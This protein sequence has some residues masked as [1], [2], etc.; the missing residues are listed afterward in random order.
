M[1]TDTEPTAPT[2]GAPE[3]LRI[4]DLVDIALTAR[5]DADAATARAAALKAAAV[6]EAERIRLTTGLVDRFPSQQ[7]LG[8]LRLD[9]ADAPAVAR[10]TKGEEFADFLAQHQSDAVTT[11]ITVPA[12]QLEAALQALEFASV[13]GVTAR[14]DPGPGAADFLERRCVIQADKDTGEWTVL[15]VD[16]EKHTHVVPGVLASKPAPRWVL[17][18]AADKKREAIELAEAD[19]RAELGAASEESA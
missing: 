19:A 11:T 8:N 10:V 17:S 15:H 13:P 6:A 4:Q 9:G 14:V 2:P 16:D 12:D 1:S 7:H 18:A 5:I 3:A